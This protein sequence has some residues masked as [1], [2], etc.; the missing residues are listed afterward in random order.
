MH[1]DGK[2]PTEGSTGGPRGPK[3]RIVYGQWALPVLEE[4]GMNTCLNSLW[5]TSFY[6]SFLDFHRVKTIARLVFGKK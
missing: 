2:G 5:Q 3:K 4:G 6:S 1:A